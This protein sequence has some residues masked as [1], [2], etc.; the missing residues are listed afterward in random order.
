MVPKASP[1]Q[2][3]GKM[4]RFS[5]AVPGW[6]QGLIMPDAVTIH[7][8]APPYATGWCN[9]KKEAADAALWQHA[10]DF[11]HFRKLI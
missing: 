5:D 10:V 2:K 4:R 8:S 7:F 1:P 9:K 6:L 3:S 11:V